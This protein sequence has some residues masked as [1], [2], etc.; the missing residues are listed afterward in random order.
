MKTN[1]MEEQNPGKYYK[2]KLKDYESPF[3]LDSMF[4]KIEPQINPDRKQKPM[5][6]WFWGCGGVIGL[7]GLLSLAFYFYPLDTVVLQNQTT[8]RTIVD[9]NPSPS[10]KEMKN[11]NTSETEIST[12]QST[13]NNYS[14]KSEEIQNSNIDNKNSY[15]DNRILNDNISN[16][17]TEI[18]SRSLPS[19]SYE[20]QFDAKDLDQARKTE[21]NNTIEN[22]INFS[23]ISKDNIL[24]EYL[25]FISLS[26]KKD[27]SIIQ[28]PLFIN[29]PNP[30]N[31]RINKNK[32]KFD[33]GGGILLIDKTNSFNLNNERKWYDKYQSEEEIY[34]GYFIKVGLG[35]KINK[36]FSII[37]SFSHNLWQERNAFAYSDS[38]YLFDNTLPN[39]IIVDRDQLPI[40]TIFGQERLDITTNNSSLV[41]NYTL[42]SMGLGLE[43][44][45]HIGNRF[46]L[47]PRTQF[48]ASYLK[49]KGMI[50]DTNG[51][52]I[53][54]SQFKLNNQTVFPSKIIYGTSLGVDLTYKVSPKFDISMDSEYLYNFN[55]FT[56][57]S[58]LTEKRN[59][60]KV[61][62]NGKWKF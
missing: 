29:I 33:L 28:L 59:L 17:S 37:S 7:L 60:L 57:S 61:G 62:L 40:D 51:S 18:R 53:E 38:T 22:E 20:L 2:E 41:S 19:N 25:P 34:P 50:I 3:D 21:I 1:T 9:K 11:V 42:T 10:S 35:R 16:V 8:Q 46:S 47:S 30:P 43:W 36:S 54:R 12:I 39:T 27:Y 23:K 55:S 14:I 44:E 4:D 45:L 56:N 13:T 31:P 15:S 5:I 58:S 49:S 52:L 6:F 48:I 24:I 32:W 26:V